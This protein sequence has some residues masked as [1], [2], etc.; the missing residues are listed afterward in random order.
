M[1]KQRVGK[2]EGTRSNGFG[3]DDVSNRHSRFEALSEGTENPFRQAGQRVRRSRTDDQN[4]S[5]RDLSEGTGRR[6]TEN[7][8]QRSF[9]QHIL[10]SLGVQSRHSNTVVDAVDCASPAVSSEPGVYLPP[11]RAHGRRSGRDSRPTSGGTHSQSESVS[12]SNVFITAR[13]ERDIARGQFVDSVDDESLFPCLTT[14]TSEDANPRT[15]HQAVGVDSDSDREVEQ[16]S[17]GKRTVWERSGTSVVQSNSST[18][19]RVDTNNSIPPGWIRMSVDGIKYGPSGDRVA[20]C[21]K[22]TE[23]MKQRAMAKLRSQVS[24]RVLE[25]YEHDCT[26][27]GYSSLDLELLFNPEDE[28]D[29]L[30]CDEV[31]T[32]G[33]ADHDGD[34]HSET[35]YDDY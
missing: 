29:F 24:Q 21:R 12:Q 19:P 25:D 8:M 17:G 34:S 15:Q 20:I 16:K 30:S 2:R 27:P 4:Q 28:E 23:S 14:N 35:S 32:Q 7:E 22:Y 18:T 5:R 31:P 13:R 33:P 26:M 3:S 6:Q 10:T 1:S 9:Q 11:G